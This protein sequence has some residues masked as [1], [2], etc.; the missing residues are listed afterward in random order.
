MIEK[1]L[2]MTNGYKSYIGLISAGMFGIAIAQGWILWADYEWLAVLIGTWTG[3][4]IKHSSDKKAA[5]K[6]K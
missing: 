5:K 2:S 4:A 3:I 1:F 6:G